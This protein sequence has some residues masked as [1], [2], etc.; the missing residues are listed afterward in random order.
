MILSKRR[1]CFFFHTTLYIV[2][3]KRSKG[4]KIFDSDRLKCLMNDQISERNELNESIS[5][6]HGQRKFWQCMYMLQCCSKD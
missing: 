3:L 6:I 1:A 4:F 2:E 5:I